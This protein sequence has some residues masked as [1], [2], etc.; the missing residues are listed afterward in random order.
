MYDGKEVFTTGDGMDAGTAAG[1]FRDFY[2]Y[3]MLEA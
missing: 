1:R 2:E 3:L